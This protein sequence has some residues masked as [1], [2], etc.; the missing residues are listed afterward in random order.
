MRKFR[1]ADL[2]F[3]SVL[4]FPALGLFATLH[5][6]MDYQP[7]DDHLF[8]AANYF[9]TNYWCRLWMAIICT[10]FSGACIG[11]LL[12]QFLNRKTHMTAERLDKISVIETQ[13]NLLQNLNYTQA[14]TGSLDKIEQKSYVLYADIL[15]TLN[16]KRKEL[17]DAKKSRNL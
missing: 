1:A 12:I 15:K 9:A 13:I 4:L 16:E 5:W 6:K 8:N 10:F 3:C 17:Y 11:I 2:I 7:T 14:Y